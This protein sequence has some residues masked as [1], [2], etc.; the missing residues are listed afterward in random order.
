M[1]KLFC[2]I[3]LRHILYFSEQAFLFNNL[4]NLYYI[5]SYFGQNTA[6][7]L[8]I[9]IIKK[10]NIPSNFG[11]IA[12]VK[13]KTCKLFITFFS[14][15][16]I[17]PL[18]KRKIKIYIIQLFAN[19]ILMQKYCPNFFYLNKLSH[20][21]DNQLFHTFNCLFKSILTLFAPNI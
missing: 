16:Q 9:T 8:F 21:I 6:N 12:S 13:K 19:Y 1:G 7:L 14:I 10:N 5:Y 17:R 11:F 4:A 20:Q 2:I 18:D 15:K 3:P